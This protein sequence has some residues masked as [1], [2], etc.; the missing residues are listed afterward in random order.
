MWKIYSQDG[1]MYCNLAKIL[2]MERGI[3]FG[4]ID[5]R[6]SDEAKS[7]FKMNGFRTVPQIFTDRDVYVG[8]Y[9]DLKKIFEKS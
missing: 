9:Q 5:V 1:C 6:S 4:E 8:G 3:E 2:M 7:L